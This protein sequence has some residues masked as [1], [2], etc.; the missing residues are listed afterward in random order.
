[1]CLIHV[2][3]NHPGRKTKGVLGHSLNSVFSFLRKKALLAIQQNKIS[4]PFHRQVMTLNSDRNVSQR[5]VSRTSFAHAKRGLFCSNRPQKSVLILL[6]QTA[7]LIRFVPDAQLFGEC[8]EIF[9][10]HIIDAATTDPSYIGV[11]S[12]RYLRVKLV[13]KVLF[14][15]F[16]NGTSAV[17]QELQIL[18]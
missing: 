3:R 8:E 15:L 17:L 4:F 7:F 14:I 18:F 16:Q 13:L 6:N 10:L 1:M 9:L 2:A 12:D 5:L 11:L